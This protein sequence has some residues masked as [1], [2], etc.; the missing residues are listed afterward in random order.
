MATRGG[1]RDF[2]GSS[3]GYFHGYGDRDGR[4]GS[5]RG[6]GYRPRGR[7]GPGF[8]FKKSFSDEVR[9][10]V[11]ELFS[12]KFV[13]QDE[14]QEW[15]VP[16]PSSMFKEEIMGISKLL[17]LKEQLNATKSKLDTKEIISWHKHTNFTNRAGGII[18]MLRKEFGPEMCT[19]AWAKFHEIVWA[20]N[21]VPQTASKCNSV[22]L[23]EAPGAFIA[24]L[25]H[26]LKTHRVDCN[27]NWKAMTLNPYY[28]GNDLIAMID[29]DKFMSET[30][31]RWYLG[32]D[33]SGDVMLW[34]NVAGLREMVKKEMEEV[35]L[36]G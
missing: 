26:Y 15:C 6:R 24:S 30:L 7:G 2:D 8:G 5:P 9:D 34:E 20:F 23:C 12:K 16:D 1:F 10:Q 11:D 36:V 35:H 25:N 21:I 29:G 27:W 4:R 19:Q 33:N 31:D 22:H 28:E 14:Y 13:F 18:P 32:V 3:S 17:D